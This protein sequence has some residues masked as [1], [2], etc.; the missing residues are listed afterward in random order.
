MDISGVWVFWPVTTLTE[1][2]GGETVI[3]GDVTVMVTDA[4]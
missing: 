2:D 4:A 1:T 3:D